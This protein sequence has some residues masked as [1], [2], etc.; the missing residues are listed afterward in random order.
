MDEATISRDVMVPMRDGT[1]LSADVYRPRRDGPHPVLVMRVPYSKSLAQTVVYAHPCWYASRGYI[2]VVQDTRGR[3]GSQGDFVPWVEGP[4][5]YDTIEWAATLEDANGRVGMYG[6]SYAGALQLQAAALH[7]PHLRAIAPAFASLDLYNDW[8]YPGGALSWAFIASWGAGDW[9]A[10]TARRS[11]DAELFERLAR[12]ADELPKAYWD[13]PIADYAY[14][15]PAAAPFFHE[16]LSHPTADGYWPL[17]EADALDS[18]A[19]PGL[20]IGGWSDVFIEGTL[21]GYAAVAGCARAEQQL[22]VGPWMHMPWTRCPHSPASSYDDI[23]AL[24]L[25]FFDR[26]LRLSAEADGP[27]TMGERPVHLFRMGDGQWVDFQRWP[28]P[29]A[30]VRWHLHSRGRA[31][32]LYGDGVLAAEAPGDGA[33]DTFVYDPANPVPSLGG[34]SCCNSDV[35]PMGFRDQRPVEERKDVLV[36]TSERL[37]ASLEVHGRV[38]LELWASSSACDTDF[39]AKLVDVDETGCALNVVD[40]ILRCRHRDPTQHEKLLEPHKVYRLEIVLGSTNWLFRTGHRV[41][42]EVSS[43]NF[44]RYSRNGNVAVHPNAVAFAELRPAQQR[45]FHDARHPSALLLPALG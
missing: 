1:L 42:L 4:D 28:A 3:F 37:D 33:A 15:P 17:P 36:Y 8:I 41:R 2:V 32:S 39:T 45:V 7:P 31:N 16:W 6:F 5:S 35:A 22:V 9:A 26:W 19:V 20:H 21:S 10:E 40:G 30:T 23:D 25:S 29:S 13:L 12:V 14:L 24:Q 38:M 11:G 27:E 44:P 18:I 43:S 34:R